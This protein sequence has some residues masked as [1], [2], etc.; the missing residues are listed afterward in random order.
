MEKL[1]FRA[2][3]EGRMYEVYQIHLHFKETPMVNISL[4]RF[5]FSQDVIP[6]AIM[7][8]TGLKDKNGKEI[9]ESDIVA[10]E[11]EGDVLTICKYEGGGF[12]LEDNAGGHWSR[13][14]WHQPERLEVI[15]NVYENENPELL[16]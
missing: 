4:P 5:P 6:E 1:K 8:F 9:Y 12:T 7:Q 13:Q 14:L 11:N 2:W 3:Y 15:G 10:V 16:S